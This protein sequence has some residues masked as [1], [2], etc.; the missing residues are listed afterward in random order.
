MTSNRP[1]GEWGKLLNYAP[2]AT[3]ILDRLL[4]HA[5]IIAL[6]GRSCRLRNGGRFED[7]ENNLLAPGVGKK[8]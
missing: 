4:H 6:K 8:K 3:A 7:Q 5:E 2:A 1:M